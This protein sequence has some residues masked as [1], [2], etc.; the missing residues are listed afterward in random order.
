MENQIVRGNPHDNNL[1]APYNGPS[2]FTSSTPITEP[3]LETV[4]VAGTPGLWPGL[5]P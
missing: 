5:E 3:L 2:D 1:Q 4:E